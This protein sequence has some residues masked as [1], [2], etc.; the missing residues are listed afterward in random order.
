VPLMKGNSI[1]SMVCLA[2]DITAQ[3]EFENALKESE[4]RYRL[5]AENARDVIWVLDENLKYMYVSPSTKRLRGFAPEEVMKSSIDKVLTPDSFRKATEI[6]SREYELEKRGM[7][8]GPDWSMTLELEMFRRDGSTI[9]TEVNVSL[10]FDGKGSPTGILGITRD[11]SDRK[12]AEKSLKEIEER[13]EQVAANAGVWVWEVDEEGIYRF[14]SPVVEMILG[15]HP[16]ELVGLKCF[17]DLFLPE[18]REKLK[19]D[20]LKTFKDR[21]PF[22]NFVNPNLHK[23]GRIVFLETS[24]TPMLD[25]KGNLIGYRG[26]DKDVTE[27][28][29]VE[30]ELRKHRDK[31]EMLVMERAAD[32]VRANDNLRQEIEV[33]KEVESSLKARESELENRQRVLEDMNVAMRVLLKQRNED[34]DAIEKNLIANINM[35]LQ[36]FLDKL[37]S[38]G[39][40]DEQMTYISE[41]ESHMKKICSSFV[42]DLSS[43][44]LGL[45]PTELRVAY[46]IKEGKS[47]KEI[48]D[49]LNVSLN[50]VLFHRNNIR[51]KV[52]LKN[53]KTNLVTYLQSLDRE[54][55]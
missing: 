48:A 12:A 45:S 19:A 44:Q 25:G 35:P 7:K 54:R 52:G 6:F 3:K 4:E 30:E 32:L 41:I 29:E 16:E 55:P 49:L 20:A 15:Y 47:S 22:R 14:A 37:K 13:F 11:I 10:I 23:D 1:A 24:G 2:R 27:Q 50:A 28:R 36:L 43:E 26:V 46:L 38:T 40:N 31:L 33:R 8:H 9:W 51:K 21:L 18:V 53:R 5:L 39:T 17:H 34:R 42:R